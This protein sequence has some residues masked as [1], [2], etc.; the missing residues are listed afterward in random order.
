MMIKKFKSLILALSLSSAAMT[1]M[2][3]D[4]AV[5]YVNP[6]IGSGGHGHVFVG[7]NVPFGYVQLGP[8]QTTRGWDWCSGYH[9]S[10]SLLV[11]FGH[12]HLKIGRA[13][14]RERV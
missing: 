11:G 4:D 12:Q 10:D 5:R 6:M 1:A 7:A 14:C 8:T 2:A 9:Y 13:S 3:I